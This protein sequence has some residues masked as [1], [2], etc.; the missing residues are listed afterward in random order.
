MEA[1]LIHI[2]AQA[3]KDLLDVKAP[4]PGSGTASIKDAAKQFEGLLVSMLFQNLRK[5]VQPS[6]LFGDDKQ[7]RSTYEYLLDQ[8]VVEH[9]LQSGQGWGLAERLEKSWSSMA[10][11]GP[12]KK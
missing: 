7:A 10:Q 1:S 11:K 2:A 4:Q 8:A 3:P 6:G 5:T 9:A 12:R